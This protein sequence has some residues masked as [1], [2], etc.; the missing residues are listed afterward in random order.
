MIQSFVEYV[1]TLR[2]DEKGE[3]QVFCD[4]L[5]RAFGHAGYK[6]AGA[7]LEFRVKAKG[8]N[9][10]FADLFWESR[11]LLEMKKRGEELQVHHVMTRDTERILSGILSGHIVHNLL[12]FVNQLGLLYL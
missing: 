4:R 2:G 1:G 12:K 3:A 6:E 11:L 9:T 5:F 8:K 10:K 7:T